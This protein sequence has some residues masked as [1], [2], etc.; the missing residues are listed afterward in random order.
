MVWGLSSNPVLC[1]SPRSKAWGHGVQHLIE[2]H[3]AVFLQLKILA[4]NVSGGELHGTISVNGRPVQPKEFRNQ[5]AVVWQ[6]DVLLSSATVRSL[7][8]R[9]LHPL[10]RISKILVPPGQSSTLLTA[11]DRFESPWSGH[12]GCSV[13]FY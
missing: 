8:H 2:N 4:C 11:Q 12:L 6:S 1:S 9:S 10:F 3:H 13:L 5:S 7:S